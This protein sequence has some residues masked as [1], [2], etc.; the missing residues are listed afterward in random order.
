M[1]SIAVI[2]AKQGHSMYGPISI[3]FGRESIDPQTDSR[4]KIYGGDSYTPTAPAVEYPVDYDRMRAVEKRLAGLSEKVA[5]GVFRND[6]ALQRAGVDEESGMSTA[7]LA[8]KL[9]RDD[10][11]RAAYLAD[12]GK[13]LEPVMQ[14]KEFNPFG[15]DALAKLVQKI[16]AQKLAD[17]EASMEAGDYQPVQEI[18]DTVRQIIRDS[19]EEQHRRFLDR[20]PELKEKR[21][22]YFM[23]NNVHTYTVDNFIISAWEY[24][25]D[26]GATTSEIDRWA[27]SDKLH[28]AASVEDVKAWLLPRLEGVLGE[29]GIYNGLDRFDRSGNRRSFSKL[30]WKYTLENIVRAMTEMQA[31]R[32]GQTFGASAKTMQ[33][34]STEDFQ[35]IDAVKAAS[36]RLGKVDTEQYKADVDAVEKRIEKATRAVMRENKAHSDN[37]F[38]EMQIIGDVMMQAAQGKQTEAAVRRVFSQEG[39]SISDS[40]AREIREVFRAAAALPTGYFEAKPQRA[41]RF[42]EAKAVI[43]PDDLSADIRDKLTE[44]GAPV[45]EYK[46]G[47]EESRLAELNAD[48]SVK[49]SLRDSAGRELTAAQ[50]DYFKD[51]KVRDAE[52]HLKV[53]YRGGNGDFTVFDRRKS[54]YSNLYGRGFYFT[55]S[56]SHAKQYGN[57]R[58]FY[59]NITNPVSTTETSITRAQ[60]RK[61]LETVAGNEDDFSFENYGYGATVDSV[62]KSTYGKSDFFMLYDV[63]QTAIGDMVQAVELFNEVNGTNYDGLILDTETVA[64]HSNQIKNTDTK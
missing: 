47:D 19:Y 58:A 46:A 11:I 45:R 17:I 41:V 32:G 57:A 62:L 7:E 23:E 10:S 2:K 50:Q 35:S 5:G 3:V 48:E 34:V 25:Q 40:T 52:G 64:F 21:I 43:V 22:N 33:A 63:S 37:Q 39:Y 9:A 61:F 59:L 15:N 28:E 26:Q 1:P 18:E 42:D 13:T 38:D 53:M 27:T 51:S 29:P 54:K 16:G 56:E 20:K 8:D 55:D 24:Y 12:Q 44:M 6:S 49:F 36:G 60:L 14:K 30:H 31:E 4:N